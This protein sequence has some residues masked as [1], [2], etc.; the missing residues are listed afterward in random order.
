[1]L[2]DITRE[3]YADNPTETI[4]HYTSFKGVLGIVNDRAIWAGDIRY[5]NDASELKHC[6]DLIKHAIADRLKSSPLSAPI[7]QA[8]I[9]WLSQR[10][11]NGH[12]LF[13]ISFRANG[14]LLSQWRGY[15]EPG[16]GV[17]LGFD[18]QFIKQCAKDQGFQIGRCIY[19]PL[20]QQRIIEQILDEVIRLIEQQKIKPL[21]RST[22]L[23][24][25]FDG[26]LPT[27]NFDIIETDLL[28]IA[29][30]I[31]HPSF[32][33]EDEW[34]LVS[35]VITDHC[36]SAV[37]FREGAS[38]LVPYLEFGLQTPTLP[39]EISQVFLGPTPNASLSMNSLKLFLSKQALLPENGLHDCQIPFRQC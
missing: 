18:S 37:K 38:M 35:P 8:F 16:K 24:D 32:Q 1:M 33:E 27:Y 31:K 7:L 20:E 29:A 6:V 28:Q 5:M 11:T 12:M 13:G 36:H 14:N 34:R 4:Y 3:L 23:E 9:V 17:S 19:H 10:M 25:G 26:G 15:S 30:V 2:T 21:E 39:M 22:M